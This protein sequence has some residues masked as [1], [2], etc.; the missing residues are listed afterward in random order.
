[1]AA[2][3]KKKRISTKGLSTLE[4]RRI[5][6][7]YDTDPKDA[8]I[9]LTETLNLKFDAT[10]PDSAA[11]NKALPTSLDPALVAPA[12]FQK[13]A[14]IAN[15]RMPYLTYSERLLY[16]EMDKLETFSE[17]R[18]RWFAQKFDR[19][20]HPR[21]TEMVAKAMALK[22]P[23]RSGDFSFSGLTLAQLDELK[24]STPSLLS[25]E[26]FN[27][28]YLRKLTP[29][30]PTELL[31]H[32]AAHAAFLAACK[33]YAMTLAA[34]AK[35]PQSPRPLPPPPPPGNPRKLPEGRLPRL[36]RTAALQPLTHPRHEGIQ[37]LR[38]H[39]GE[40]LRHHPM[41]HGQ[42]RFRPHRV[43][44]PP[45]PQ[46]V[47]YGAETLHPP[48]PG[49]TPRPP[50]RPCP[51]ARRG[52][53]HPLGRRASAG[54]IQD[55]ARGDTHHL[56]PHRAAALRR[57][58]ERIPAARSE[59]HRRAPHPHLRAGG[60]GGR[61]PLHRSRWPRPAQ[62]PHHFLQASPPRPPPRVHRPPRA[63]RCRPVDRGIRLQS[64]LRPRP[65][66]QRQHHPAH[67]P[68]GHGPGNPP[69]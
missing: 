7:T 29:A 47:R 54:G 69:L 16:R 26:R 61:L 30:Y 12:A 5:L 39:G 32:P 67:H 59:K 22:D 20:D 37:G 19:Q 44:P 4:N 21:Y 33:D 15:P 34:L 60:R 49:E 14:E 3:D 18:L 65:R 24:K 66:P 55:P 41:P 28:D 38:H 58:G 50:P 43:L 62:D 57:G 52:R 2:E 45:F 27:T 53:S 68:H 31:R 63:N 25:N 35:L 46:R 13:V 10:K 42:Q 1:M 6:L 9:E 64:D 23:V 56:R 8:L 40:F 51:P 36:P 17:S 11:T 48:H